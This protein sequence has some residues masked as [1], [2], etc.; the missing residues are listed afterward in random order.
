MSLLNSETIIEEDIDEH[1]IENEI[2]KAKEYG[3]KMVEE[4]K[5]NKKA[6]ESIN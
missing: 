1:I 3:I 6:G 2:N 5:E 4:I